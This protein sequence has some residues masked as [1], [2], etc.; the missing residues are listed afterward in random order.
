M[1][2]RRFNFLAV[3]GISLGSC[4]ALAAPGDVPTPAPEPTVV[5]SGS[6]GES[7]THSPDLTEAKGMVM[8]DYQLIPVP[9][10]PSIDLMGFHFLN[11]MNDGLHMGFGGYAPLF[12]GEYGGFMILDVTAHAQHRI[13]GKLFANAGV[14]LGGGG[15]GKS[16]LQSKEL[17]G[18]G[19]F[20]KAYVG[21]GYDFDGFS[22]GA[23]IARTKLSNSAIDHSQVNVFVQIPFS[24]AIGPYVSAGDSFLSSAEAGSREAGAES[25]ESMLSLGLDNFRQIDPQGSNKGTINLADLQFSHFLTNNAYSYFNVGIG[26]R[27]LPLHNQVIGG[28][29]YRLKLTPDLNLYGQLGLGSG[30]YAPDTIDTGAGLLVYPKLSAEYMASRNL[31][32]ALSAGYMSAPSGSSKNYTYGAVLN[33]H[34]HGGTGGSGASA[35]I[36]GIYSGYR[37]HL[38]QQTELNVKFNNV[39]RNNI[40]MLSVQGDKIVSDNFYIPVQV[41]VAYNDHLGLPG[42]GEFL[43][44]VGVQN[45]YD[46]GDRVQ[47][48][49]QLLVGTNV[50]GPILKTGIGLNVGLSDGLAIYG[51]AG[52]THAGTGSNSG[53]FRSDYAGIGLTY[54]FSMPSR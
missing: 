17:S 36:D 34:L 54:R 6:T 42:Y 43:A 20:A 29:G 12:E 22:A 48:F 27:G 9:G 28:L 21:L 35:V 26:Y 45:K 30:G 15:G 8:L 50:H 19:G 11:R 52:Q 44:G 24:Y 1:T 33:Y 13:S 47:V 31:G 38:F 3:L 4:H 40:K 41:S 14:S 7:A 51:Q 25:S 49:G 46:K 32:L 37:F 39:D 2:R 16:M 5:S 10:N 53:K 18:T 23:N